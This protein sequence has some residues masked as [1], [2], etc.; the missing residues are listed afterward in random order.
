MITVECTRII[1]WPAICPSSPQLALRSPFSDVQSR[2]L[3]MIPRPGLLFRSAEGKLINSSQKCVR[4]PFFGGIERKRPKNCDF[5][6]S[7]SDRIGK[8]KISLHSLSSPYVNVQLLNLLKHADSK[9]RGAP[10]R[11]RSREAHRGKFPAQP[12]LKRTHTWGV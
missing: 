8:E 12:P 7:L 6:L 11:E 9:A 1:F 2:G 3:L 5:S 4:R 10:C